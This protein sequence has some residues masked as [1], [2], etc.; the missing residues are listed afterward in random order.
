LAAV[1]ALWDAQPPIQLTHI[2][3]SV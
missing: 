3:A 1:R 2:N